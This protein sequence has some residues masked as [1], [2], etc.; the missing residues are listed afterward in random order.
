MTKHLP[1]VAWLTGL[2][3]FLFVCAARQLLA[4]GGSSSPNLTVSGGQLSAERIIWAGS[5]PGALGGLKMT[6]GLVQVES[7]SASIA[8]ASSANLNS[9]AMT[10]MSNAPGLTLDGTAVL[11]TDRLRLIAGGGIVIADDAVLEVTRSSIPASQGSNLISQNHATFDFVAQFISGNWNQVQGSI[12]LAS[13]GN[14][15][16]GNGA[17]IVVPGRSE[18]LSIG[19]GPF[20]INFEVLLMEAINNG[21]IVTDVPGGELQVEWDGI[22]TKVWV[23]VPQASVDASYVFHPGWS[24]TLQQS[25]NSSK[26]L[27]REN[28]A[29][30]T[31]S[32]ANVINSSSGINGL[33][34]DLQDPGNSA[35]ISASDF[36]FQVSPV[37][38]FNQASNPVATWTTAPQPSSVTVIP[39]NPVRILLQWSDNAIAHR[40][41]RITL[42]DT[43]NTGLPEPEVFYIGHL[44][45]ETNGQIQGDGFLVSFDDILAIRQAVG[46]TVD[47]SS[48]VDIDKNGIVQFG[49]ISL[50]R[51]NIGSGLSSITI[52]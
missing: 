26:Q 31:L 29:P 13:P 10:M 38:T 17:L 4:D 6:G 39:G 28:G 14:G 48:N 44:L 49:D 20:N 30:Q 47:A 15:Q 21:K 16:V 1:T 35:A 18:T 32:F 51:P 45:G 42:L 40:W 36:V 2:L 5:T 3:S 43:P 41:L 37:G 34:F 23:A 9:G 12:C 8:A 19:G 50:M 25:I 7:S 22:Y 11:Q 27:A 33:I 52:P 46:S 24:G